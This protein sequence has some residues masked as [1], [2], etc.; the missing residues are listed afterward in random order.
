MSKE[1]YYK[2]VIFKNQKIKKNIKQYKLYRNANK[3][4][5]ELMTKCEDIIFEKQ[6]NTKNE[7]LE[8]E[9]GLISNQPAN[10]PVKNSRGNIIDHELLN[11]EYIRK[12]GYYAE[13]ELIWYRNEKKYI[14]LKEM[15][16]F[17]LTHE[18]DM[19]YLLKNKIITENLNEDTYFIFC[20]KNEIDAHR[21]F[22][23]I[24]DFCNA[25]EI[26]NFIFFFNVNTKDAYNLTQRLRKYIKLEYLYFLR[27][28]T[29]N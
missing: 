21:L 15:I 3:K 1:V 22:K 25:N 24:V 9:V 8:Y 26:P 10:I 23:I 13:E 2:I 29:R 14:T 7:L 5:N 4:F 20:L 17:I 19:F 12:L 27:N 11:N 28:T 18:I 16:K 6:Y